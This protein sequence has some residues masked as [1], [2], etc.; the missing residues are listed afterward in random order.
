MK[1]LWVYFRKSSGDFKY[2]LYMPQFQACK[3]RKKKFFL[4]SAILNPLEIVSLGSTRCQIA[5][6][7]VLLPMVYEQKIFRY[8]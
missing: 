3:R 1:G 7:D 6:L 4:L 5:G 2:T 8:I